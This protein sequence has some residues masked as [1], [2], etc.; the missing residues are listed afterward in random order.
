MT[1]VERL[2]EVMKSI[3][4]ITKD[5]KAPGVMGGYAFRGIDDYLE[6]THP[7]FVKHGVI[8]VPQLKAVSQ[9]DRTTKNGG[10][11]IYTVVEVGY[12]I[13]DIEGN[14]LFACA[15]GEAQDS[16][17]KSVNKAMSSAFKNM[18][19]QL[20]C[21][22]TNDPE[23]DSEAAEVPEPAKGKTTTKKPAAGPDGKEIFE[24]LKTF[25]TLL[26]GEE[27]PKVYCATLLTADG[28]AA[29]IPDDKPA[30]PFTAIQMLQKRGVKFTA[31]G[32]QGLT[33]KIYDEIVKLI[34][35]KEM[36]PT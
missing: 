10:V 18:L 25:I 4:A 11:A 5:R 28:L 36:Q 31:A 8:A 13:S 34:G 23:S 17:D 20:L 32:P 33:D 6:A 14:E 12:Q 19:T 29:Q 3:G 15:P 24:N 27:D 35:E 16:G 26:V 2:I 7:A 30:I 21:I 1:I 9:T 22:P